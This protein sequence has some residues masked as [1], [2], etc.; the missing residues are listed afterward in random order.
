MLYSTIN[1]NSSEI[2]SGGTELVITIPNGLPAHSDIAIGIPAYALK[3]NYNT[4]FQG[5]NSS[6]WTFKTGAKSSINFENTTEINLYPNPCKD[7]VNIESANEIVQIQL[8]DVYGKMYTLPLSRISDTLYNLDVAEL[9][10]GIY[11]IC[12]GDKLSIK[13]IKL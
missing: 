12:I 6:I 11:V 7:I 3:D 5:V 2:E 13:L 10:A 9:P 8:I 4:W 1:L